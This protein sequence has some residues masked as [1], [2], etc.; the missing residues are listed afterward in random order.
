MKRRI[1][2]VAS[3]LATLAQPNGEL[4]V[5]SVSTS[6]HAGPTGRG[7]LGPLAPRLNEFGYAEGQNLRLDYIDMQ[8]RADLYGDAM[9]QLVA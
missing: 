8:G 7:F 9:Q 4:R 6:H 2:I 3:P 1:F 5:G